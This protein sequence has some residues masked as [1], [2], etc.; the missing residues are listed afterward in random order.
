MP[1][2]LP[3]RL[4]LL[5]ALAPALH[6]GASTSVNTTANT[7]TSPNPDAVVAELQRTLDA[8]L[9]RPDAAHPPGLTARMEAVPLMGLSIAVIHRGQLHWARGFGEA[10]AGVPVTTETR[11]QAGSISKP[12]AALGAMALA[13]ARG[14]GFDDDLAPLLRSWRPEPEAGVTR[15]S[16]R[17]LLSHS[18]GLTQHGF[19]GYAVG[20]QLPTLPQ[21]LDGLPPANSGAVRPALP[22]G[23]AWRYSGGGSTIAQLWV[24]DASGQPYAEALAQLALRPME[25][26]HSH[27]GPPAQA[28]DPRYAQSHQ[29]R[30]P[31]P[32][33]WRVYP[34][35]AA[36]GLWST[37]S[38]IARMLI[39]VQRA[40]Q[41]QASPVNPGVARAA[42]TEVLAPSSMGFFI[43]GTGDEARFGH[44][45]SNQGFESYAFSYIGQGEGV[46]LM[47]NGQNSWGLMDAAVRTL[48]R[49]YGWPG[50]A[51]PQALATTQQKLPPGA[52]RWAGRYQPPAGPPLVVRWHNGALWL[53]K[54]PGNWQRLWR[55]VDGA[56]A[57][58]PDA[59]PPDGGPTRLL[60]S[61]LGLQLNPQDPVLP[62]L[63]LARSSPPTVYLRG[64][65]NGWQASQALQPAGPGR[66]RTT[67]TL[68][69]GEHAFKLGDA[70]WGRLNLGAGSQGQMPIGA[71]LPLQAQGGNLA[72]QLVAPGRFQLELAGNLDSPAPVRLRLSPLL[73]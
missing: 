1:V 10:R 32:G 49:L 3:C 46:V 64:S 17:R 43:A 2:A 14:V 65:F 68:P 18:A 12:V 36:A 29:G 6:A 4:I 58:D 72:L 27:F 56:W 73:P 23:Q 60:L 69:A 37:P 48:A 51:A 61:A 24:E 50:M 44:N 31:E 34:E 54:G 21:V 8:R 35:M 30:K 66:W 67:V 62:R 13:Q 42:T 41:G 63:A 28:D 59:A 57:T 19:Q 39:A 70:E 15:Y 5:L 71:W 55:T 53:D 33:G 22:P 7:T 9:R 16:L 20:A 38:D 25:M 26:A 45:G 40:A 52:A 11:F 47:A